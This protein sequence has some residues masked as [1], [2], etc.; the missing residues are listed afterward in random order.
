MQKEKQTKDKWTQKG[1]TDRTIQLRDYSPISAHDMARKKPQR[2]RQVLLIPT[3]IIA[4]PGLWWRQMDAAAPEMEG[5]N[6][7]IASPGNT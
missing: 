2:D 4:I 5:D 1:N 3:R 6:A 7:S